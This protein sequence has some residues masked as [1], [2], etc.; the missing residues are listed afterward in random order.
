MDIKFDDKTPIYVQIMYLIKMDIITG[1]LKEDDKLPSVR[2]LS[3]KLKVNPNTIQRAYQE[4][5]RENLTY[6]QRGTGNFVR[7]NEKMVME[8]KKEMAKQ[9]IDAFIQDMRNLGFSSE[10]IIETVG[11]ELRKEGGLNGNNIKGK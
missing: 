1:K 10:E 8:L 3:S 6:T 11:E 2:E 9:S 5:E 4:L 7:G